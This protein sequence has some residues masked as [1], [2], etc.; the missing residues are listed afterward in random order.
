MQRLTKLGLAQLLITRLFPKPTNDKKLTEPQAM[1]LIA[2]SRDEYV[3]QYIYQNRLDDKTIH[4]EWLSTFKGLTPKKDE[5]CGDLYLELPAR[6]IAIFHDLSIYHVWR[7]GDESDLILPRRIGESW[8]AGG[9]DFFSHHPSYTLEQ[10]RLVFKNLEQEGCKISIRMLATAE[11]IGA[12]D[13]F[14]IDG[15]AVS[16]II[17]N[18]IQRYTITKQIPEDVLNDNISQ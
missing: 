12:T 9:S 1:L 17:D 8:I 14:P 10:D 2:Q 6:S 5:S 18:A 11:D 4:T 16:A 13:Y 15:S 3:K 7:G